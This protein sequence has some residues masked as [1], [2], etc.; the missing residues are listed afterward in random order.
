MPENFLPTDQSQLSQLIEQVTSNL[1][2]LPSNASLIQIEAQDPNQKVENLISQVEKN[3]QSLDGFSVTLLS[4]IVL[5]SMR[6]KS[7]R[8]QVGCLD[9][10][11]K[12]IKDKI[13][14]LIEIDPFDNDF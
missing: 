14:S 7:N 2:R 10:T 13:K 11:T 12:S 6:I 5:L 3:N 9:G 4:V 8:D 1:S